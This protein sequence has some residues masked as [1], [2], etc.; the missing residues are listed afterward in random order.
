MMND[1]Y[2]RTLTPEFR[3]EINKSINKQFEELNTCSNNALVNAQKCGLQ[4]HAVCFLRSTR[5]V[6][7]LQGHA[8]R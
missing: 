7:S 3:D 2:Y 4:A 6:H 8:Q 5:K 1:E